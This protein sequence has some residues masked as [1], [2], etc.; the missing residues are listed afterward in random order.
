MDRSSATDY[1]YAKSHGML[2]KSFVGSRK[3]NLFAAKT[4]S[5]LWRL[6]FKTSAPL[7]PENM[8]ARAIEEEAE[9]TFIADYI[10]LLSSF[11]EPEHIAVH[12][13]RFYEYQNIK[14]IN[15]AI[16]RGH[17]TIPKIA[18]I[19]TY[20][21]LH[22]DQ[23]PKVHLITKNTD[24]EW[25]DTVPTRDTQ[26]D[27]DSRL[28][29]Q[30]TKELWN[31]VQKLSAPQK[32]SVEKLI[33]EQIILQNVLWA[34]RLKTYYG[35]TQTQI[36]EQLVYADDTRPTNDLLAGAALA[37]VD[38]QSDLWDNWSD[39]KYV[40]L[41]NPSDGVSVWHIDP[42][43]L[44]N[45][46]NVHLN[47]MAYKSFSKNFYSAHILVSWYKIKEYELNCIRTCVEG[48]RLNVDTEQLKQFM[49]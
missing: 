24:I 39:W 3:G 36:E 46:I 12:L 41:L 9:R 11:D 18:D 35:Y 14:E 23:W 44:Q 21:Q 37:T 43:W 4:L 45:S 16:L 48:L 17:T 27:V 34:I 30:Y 26:K 33:K 19:G 7:I 15:A 49:W 10:N 22:Y 5:D 47:K 13:L 42:T 40:N 6:L 2:A 32:P 28:D 29:I 8:L 1:V 20:A 25:L 31:S 38:K